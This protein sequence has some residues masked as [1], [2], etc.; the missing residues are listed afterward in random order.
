MPNNER[1]LTFVERCKSFLFRRG[2]LPQGDFYDMFDRVRDRFDEILD[3]KN[4]PPP[5]PVHTILS[6]EE[7]ENIKQSRLAAQAAWRAAADQRF[8]A[9]VKE[10]GEAQW[11]RIVDRRVANWLCY[12]LISGLVGFLIGKLL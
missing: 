8:M 6:G 4:L 3:A 1:I 5:I 11:H 9:V 2:H 10:E 7:P 12:P